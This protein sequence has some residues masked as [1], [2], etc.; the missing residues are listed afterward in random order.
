MQSSG[1]RGGVAVLLGA[2]LLVGC[3]T[4][5][6]P[7]VPDN[8]AGAGATVDSAGQGGTSQVAGG[9]GSL[10]QVRRYQSTAS[11]GDFIEVEIDK[12]ARTITYNNRTNG[13]S[14]S[15]V[16]YTL[17][18]RGVYVI[19][20]DPNAHLQRAIE[21]D[22][23][24]LIMDV[25]KA[26]PNKDSRALAIGATTQPISIADLNGHAMTMMQFRTSNG[27][28]E[29]GNVRTHVSDR[30][31]AVDAQSYWPLGASSRG[32]TAFHLGGPGSLQLDE[33]SGAADYLTI[34]ES[35]NGHT[36]TAYI[37]KTGQGLA[38]DMNNGNMVMVDQPQSTAFDP[39]SAGLYH[40]LIYQKR[41]SR[42]VSEG[43][44]EPGT[45]EVFEVE[46]AINDQGHLGMKRDGAT[47]EDVDLIPV[48][49]ADYL[50]G[51]NKLDASRCA[52]LFTY[53]KPVGAGF[54][55]VFVV[56]MGHGMLVSSFTPSDQNAGEYQYFYGAAIKQ[57]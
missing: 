1:L 33:V 30:M 3:A 8:A 16:P 47:V 9:S 27:G 55:D 40:A 36:S 12:Q 2:A 11:V 23:Y 19:T 42:R 20:A 41:N 10:S 15:A 31:L 54:Q 38:I 4:A 44:V 22:G 46:V 28:M 7:T 57:P 29:V 17:D 43:Q 32:D 6:K 39:S 24:A 13:Q 35:R 25:A 45:A 5:A 52:G 18:D 21:L 49:E 51:P 48:S 34:T 14:A 26:G 50:T 53:R 37:F 56:F